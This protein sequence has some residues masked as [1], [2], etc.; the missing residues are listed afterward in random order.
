MGFDYAVSSRG[1]GSSEPELPLPEQLTLTLDGARAPLRVKA[2]DKE[3]RQLTGIEI[4][5]WYIQKAGRGADIN[6]LA[7]CAELTGNDGVATF[8]WLPREFAG[9]IGFLSHS[10]KH[11]PIDHATWLQAQK[12]ADALMI[13]MLPQ[14]RLSG[15]VTTSDGRPAA[16]VT[17]ALRG[18]GGG[19]NGFQGAARTDAGGRY[20]LAV[21]SEQAY[22]ITASRGDLAAPYRWGVIVRA[23]KPI[24]GVDLVLGPST[25]VRG[26]VTLGT[27]RTPV[28]NTTV[29]AVI[30]KGSI[31]DELK[32]PGDRVHRAM[33]LPQWTRTDKQGRFE[34]RLGPGE[35]RIQGPPRTEPI[36][37][38]IPATEPP[39]EIVRDFTMPRTETGPFTA[40]V[41]DDA[42]KPTARAIVNG[43]YAATSAT[44]WFHQIE[45]DASGRFRTE[46]ALDPLV[47]HAETPDKTRAGVM[48]SDSESR[49]GRIVVQ[50]FAT[51]SGQLVDPEGKPIAGRKLTYGIRIYMGEPGSSSFTSS[52]GGS[53][54]TDDQ[55]RFTL[56]GLAVAETYD[57]DA[58]LDESSSRTATQVIPKDSRPIV[59]GDIVA[60]LSPPKP[61]IPPTPA[62]RA[63]E[64]FAA[65]KAMSAPEKLAYVLTEA[66][67]EY[68]RPL[69]LFGKPDDSACVQLF[70]L[71]E[72]NSADDAKDKSR[73]KT[74]AE[75]RWEFELAALDNDAPDVTAL[76]RELGI[77]RGEGGAVLAVLNEKGTL[78][79]TYPLRLMTDNTLD[80]AALRAFLG[81]HKLATRDAE[82]MLS[83]ALGKAR[84]EGQQVFLIMSASWCGP[85]RL[86][87]RFL[88]A[89]KSELERR[90][91]FVKLDVSRDEHAEELRTRYEKGQHNGV[92]WYVILDADGTPL[93]TSNTDA[94]K[95]EYGMSNIGFPSSKAGIDHFLEMLKRTAPRISAETLET[96]RA[97]LAKK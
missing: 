16:D 73:S 38:T 51:A 68:T 11:Y 57:V 33:S 84:A 65:R 2:V 97:A 70:R 72:D 88:A 17:V 26:Q 50:P 5:P 22:I 77:P 87:A 28:A 62:E 60:D 18:Q 25:R 82:R 56:G 89:N 55:G 15:R 96:L 74:P 53:M 7:K 69:L 19:M 20:E 83:E 92:P 27:D 67:R 80:A 30:D 52:F 61:C 78:A 79:A 14:E 39:A 91:V 1:R 42:G 34:F 75:L 10:D 4:S 49:E 31:P 71:F 35:H 81:E 93:V 41:V 64:A 9:A 46:R 24:D 6:G 3:N 32:R 44:W 37:V 63:V 45:T 95:R 66:K 23:G 12:P 29:Q 48:R 40:T 86:L 36:E 43:V 59:L 21:Y 58:S 76:A 90:Y 54:T 8:D 85:C 94:V 47:L 13:P